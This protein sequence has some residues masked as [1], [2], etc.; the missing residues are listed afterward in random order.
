L[1]KIFNYRNFLPTKSLIKIGRSP[2]S[3]ISINDNML[4]RLHCCIEYR[5]NVGWILRDGY[6]AKLKDGSYESKI[7]T[8]GTW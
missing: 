8:N 6:L 5:E 3:E 7:S 2:N 4:S 1:I